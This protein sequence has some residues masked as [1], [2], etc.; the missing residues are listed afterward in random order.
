MRTP[1]PVREEKRERAL[2]VGFATSSQDRWRE[3]D[4]LEEL[5]QLA[6]TA[7]AEVFEKI[8]QIREKP[9]P[10]YLLGRGKVQE[11]RKIVE[12]FGLDLVIVN[13]E[14]SPSQHRNL[15][16][17][18]GVKIID[19]TELI[20]DIFAQHART[21]EAKI[22]VELAQLE[23]RL[24]KLVGKG[25]E[26][27]RLGGG[28]GTRGPGEKKLEIDRRRIEDRIALLRR[29]L[30]EIERTRALQRKRRQSLFKVSLVGYTNTGKSTLMNQLTR[31]GVL[32]ED[33]LFATLDAVTRVLYHP[34][35]R[36]RI[37]LSDTVGFI[38]NLPHHL[39]ASFRATLGVVQE[40][41]LLAHVVDVSHPR[42]EERMAVVEEVLKE[43]GVAHKPRIVVFNKMDLLLETNLVERLRERYPE[44][45]FVSALTGEGLD[46]L[47]RRIYHH[48]EQYFSRLHRS[49]QAREVS[50]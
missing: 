34:D 20:L 50:P 47:L 30:R 35:R 22:Q 46:T 32:V 31:A 42:L 10:S 39:V 33:Q 5:E 44:S 6:H 24:S 13:R 26:L 43:I 7:G 3:M 4:S 41:D 36:V 12:T 48:A 40:A 11:I 45:V 21:A 19:R 23:Y 16:E 37:V 49:P 38:E 15:E 27:S 2:L 18:I 8:L 14:L 29:K 9:D 17:A 28:I 25:T 1:Q